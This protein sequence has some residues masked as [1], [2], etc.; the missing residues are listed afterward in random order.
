MNEN[1][2]YLYALGCDKNTVDAE[3]ILGDLVN[4][5]FKVVDDLDDASL[6]IVN[7]CCFID[8][9][10]E[11]SIAAIFESLNYK[12]S[13]NAKVIVTGCLSES[14]KEELIEE[15]PEIDGFFKLNESKDILDFLNKEKSQDEKR[16]LT[17]NNYAYL[18]ISEGCNRNCSYCSIPNIRGRHLSRN[19]EDIISE[20]KDLEKQGVKELILVAQDLTQYGSDLKNKINFTNLLKELVNETNFHWIRLLYL[21]PEGI[22]SELIDLIS[23]NKNIVPYLDIPIQHT[24]DRILQSMG[25]WISRERIFNLVKELREKIPDIIIRSTVIVGYPGETE[26]EFKS[27]L[28]DLEELKIDRLG[29]FAYSREE[30]TKAF[31]MSDQIPEE[32]KEDR[33]NEVTQLQL[34]LIRESNQ[35]LLNKELDFLVEEKIDD[36]TYSGRVFADSPE[37]DCLTYIN[38]NKE[39]EVGSVVPVILRDNLD[40]ELIGDLNE[41][42]K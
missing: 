5:G 36:F 11:E 7:T 18:K 40:F 22:T 37:I 28:N 24:N 15:I 3:Y 29:A 17:S 10:K 9:A 42:S 41:S 2:V 33:V 23:E 26:E 16:F 19:K 31:S 20:A 6:I 1:T 14:Y 38:S 39:L 8:K 34:E 27:L 21:Y 30:G 4:A 13:N 32:V 25:R 35:K 12:D